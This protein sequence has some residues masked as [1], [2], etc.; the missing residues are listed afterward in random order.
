MNDDSSRDTHSELGRTKNSHGSNEESTKV[1]TEPVFTDFDED[2]DYEAADRDTD[3]VGVYD[4]DFD[5]EESIDSSTDTDTDELDD[6]WQVLGNSAQPDDGIEEGSDAWEEEDDPYGDD[7]LDEYD[8]YDEDDE[9]ETPGRSLAQASTLAGLASSTP[10]VGGDWGRNQVYDTDFDSQVQEEASAQKSLPMGLI[11][12]GVIALALLAAGGYGVVQERADSAEEIRQLRATLAT[13]ANPAEVEASRQAVA[14]AEAQN[15]KLRATVQRLSD[16]NRRL[17]DTI[18]SLENQLDQQ[19]SAL[20]PQ[21]SSA[22]SEEP[23]SASES[24][25]EATPE[26]IPDQAPEP[27]NTGTASAAT[28]VTEGKWFVNFSS[29]SQRSVAVDWANKLEPVAGSTIVAASDR[30]GRTLYRVRIIGL[31]DRAEARK[32]A[33]QLQTEYKLPPLWVGSD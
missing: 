23:S 16:E 4:E 15:E 11:G 22:E 7:D 10:G 25:P 29:Y 27:P 9:D 28:T 18:A 12:V 3:F 8:P 32:V 31:A 2:E 30:D 19:V 33:E 21:A 1:R 13:T 5:Q 20:Y 17:G 14:E 24:P 26:P 6:D